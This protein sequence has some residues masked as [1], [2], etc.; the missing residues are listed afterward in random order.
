[1]AGTAYVMPCGE[2]SGALPGRMR[3]KQLLASF[4]PLLFGIYGQNGA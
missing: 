1:M 3:L 4:T 2:A